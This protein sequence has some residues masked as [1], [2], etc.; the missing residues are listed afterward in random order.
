[1]TGY[2]Q[3]LLWATHSSDTIIQQTCN[4]PKKFTNLLTNV[5]YKTNKM[6]ANIV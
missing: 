1:M 3:I 2:Y 5:K 4:I 6:L